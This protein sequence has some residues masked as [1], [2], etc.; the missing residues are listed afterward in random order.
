MAKN[1][2]GA[3]RR[4]RK[5]SKKRQVPGWVWLFTGVAAGLFLAFLVHL[6]QV[7]KEAG[8]AT[9]VKAPE[10]SGQDNAKGTDKP[11]AGGDEPTFDFYAVLPK[12]EVIV[13][14][15]KDEKTAPAKKPATTSRDD[16][17]ATASKPDTSKSNNTTADTGDGKIYMLQAGS[18]RNAGDADRRR[19]ELILKGYEVRLQPVKLENGDTWHRVMIG[20]YNSVNTL[21]K[22]QDQLASNGVETLPIQVK[23]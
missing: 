8:T 18:F 15:S 1:T 19:A 6:A 16:K 22:A 20:P 17:P 11:K 10:Q 13:P 12:M 7:Q 9:L 5:N 23:K 21:H 14:K 4:P 2:R 3:S